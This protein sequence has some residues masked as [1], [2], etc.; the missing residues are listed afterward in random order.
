MKGHIKECGISDRL[1]RPSLAILEEE[2]GKYFFNLITDTLHFNTEVLGWSEKNFK[3]DGY[4]VLSPNSV[5]SWDV[6]SQNT[7]TKSYDDYMQISVSQSDKGS[8]VI[9]MKGVLDFILQSYT[10]EGLNNNMDWESSGLEDRI[11][12]G[13]VCFRKHLRNYCEEYSKSHS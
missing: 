6:L 3:A 4:N 13:G 2:N 8:Y 1:Y 7:E 5:I 12:L 9:K 10:K 11:E